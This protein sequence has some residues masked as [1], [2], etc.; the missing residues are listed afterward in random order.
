MFGWGYVIEHCISLFKKEQEE[1][2]YRNY[3]A[4]C[5]RISTENIAKITTLLTGGKE[6]CKYVGVSFEDMIN[7]KPIKQQTSDEIIEHISNK[8]QKIGG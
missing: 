7:P 2:L 1:K 6:E 8:L 4:E 5:L 3:V